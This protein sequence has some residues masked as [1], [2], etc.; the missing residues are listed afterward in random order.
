MKIN[1]RQIV[2]AGLL[3]GL[4]Y[5]MA[6]TPW[7]GF[8]PVPTPAGSATT[9]HIPAILG[10][11]LE[12]PVVGA[13]VGFIFGLSSFLRS[14]TPLFKDPLIAFGP[15]IL[16]G[17]M[18]YY[19]YVLIGRKQARP[20]AAVAVGLLIARLSYES[21]VLFNTK[22]AGLT[23]A[24]TAFQQALHGLTA[25]T[26]LVLSLALAL[27]AALGYLTH[28]LVRREDAP[29]AIAAVVGTLTNTVLVLT[30]IGLRFHMKAEA[31]WL[32]GITQGL[33]EVFVA[34]VLTVVVAKG[35]RRA[36][37]R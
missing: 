10:G 8:I 25:N 9:M 1:T 12:G 18:A 14:T 13:F 7:L 33:P 11:I 16:I 15:R 23:A 36:L 20:V 26:P 30:L 29:T 24:P 5:V 3:G 2:V 21:A 17:V 35:V 32:V 4:S 34:V 6:I 37:N 27:G 22:F 31:L 28:R 19:A